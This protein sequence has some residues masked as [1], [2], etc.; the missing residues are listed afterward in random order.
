MQMNSSWKK[1][2]RFEVRNLFAVQ[3][4]LFVFLV[5]VF[6]F[7]TY[8]R[9]TLHLARTQYLV[10]CMSGGLV[11]ILVISVLRYG[12]KF[13]LWIAMLYGFIS[14]YVTMILVIE[15]FLGIPIIYWYFFGGE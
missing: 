4:L 15:L 2:V 6:Q 10:S 14:C 13:R 11:S 1:H 12:L 5:T 7:C 3:L 8:L 9:D